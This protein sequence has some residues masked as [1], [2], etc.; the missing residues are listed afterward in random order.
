MQPQ[1]SSAPASEHRSDLVAAA[2]QDNA[3]VDYYQVL[4]RNKQT[5]RSVRS[6]WMLLREA[7]ATVWSA[8][9]RSSRRCC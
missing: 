3:H 2:A 1:V 8:G 5:K 6:F 4:L 7:F 9:P